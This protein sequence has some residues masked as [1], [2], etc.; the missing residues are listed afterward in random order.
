M[1]IVNDSIDVAAYV[2]KQCAQKN[3]FVNL[4][5]IQ[6]LVFCVYGAVL[7][8][9]GERICKDHPKAWPHGPVFPRIYKYTKRHADGIVEALMSHE[10]NLTSTLNERQKKI[11]D[12]TLNFFGRYNAGTLVNWTHDENGPWFKSTN[13]GKNLQKEIPDNLISDYFKTLLEPVNK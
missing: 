12:T 8:T 10:E 3:F 7:A 2:T 5:K 9:S 4:T 11:I 1:P 13:G 6:K